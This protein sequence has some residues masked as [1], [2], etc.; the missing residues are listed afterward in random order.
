[1][2]VEL[3]YNILLVYSNVYFSGVK[4]LTEYLSYFK[5]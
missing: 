2:E 1:M 3:T 4:R 5:A